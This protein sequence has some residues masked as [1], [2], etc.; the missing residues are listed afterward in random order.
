MYLLYSLTDVNKGLESTYFKLRVVAI[1]IKKVKRLN[2]PLY[3]VTYLGF[4]SLIDLI[5]ENLKEHFQKF[6]YKPDLWS[7]R[8]P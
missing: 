4:I 2:L 6:N 7:V 8:D 5:M 1:K 3:L